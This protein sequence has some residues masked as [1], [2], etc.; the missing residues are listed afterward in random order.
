MKQ[1]FILACSVLFSYNVMAQEQEQ[2]KGYLL[3]GSVDGKI[4]IT[5]FL[6]TEPHPCEP[7]LVYQGIYKYNKMQAKGDNWLL[8]NID[9]NDNEQFI[10]AEERFT[11]VLILKK[12]NGGF[13][14]IW[15]HPN[16]TTQKKVELKE[17]KLT[18]ND[19]K[20]YIDVLDKVNYNF[21]DC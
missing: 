8:L 11:G 7:K 17:K 21:R 5:M 16:G 12:E 10:M 15:M 20:K 14:G 4:E 3:T 18:E 2:L 1:L 9:Y 13:S 6:T 19:K